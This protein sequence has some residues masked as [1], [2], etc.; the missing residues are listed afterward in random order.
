MK[1]MKMKRK[2]MKIMVN[3]LKVCYCCYVIYVHWGELR[4]TLAKDGANC[5]PLSS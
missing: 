5:Y 1:V 4:L 2:T 3:E